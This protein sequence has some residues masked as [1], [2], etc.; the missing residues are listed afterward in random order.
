MVVV[1]RAR[2]PRDTLSTHVF[3]AQGLAFLDRLGV[4]DKIRATGAPFLEA[5]EARLQDL[6]FRQ[7]WPQREGDVGG[8]TSVRRLLLDPI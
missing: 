8:I 7:P 2:F 4:T 5:T 6:Q 3:Q 1:D